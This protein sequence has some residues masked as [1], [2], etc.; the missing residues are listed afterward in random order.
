MISFI[1]LQCLKIMDIYADDTTCAIYTFK[2]KLCNTLWCVACTKVIIAL[3][4]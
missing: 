4:K 1:P 3:R 2:A